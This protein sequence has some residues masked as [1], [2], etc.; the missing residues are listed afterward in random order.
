MLMGCATMLWL[1]GCCHKIFHDVL[2]G[3]GAQ[4]TRARAQR[5]QHESR[6]ELYGTTAVTALSPE[7]RASASLFVYVWHTIEYDSYVGGKNHGKI[8]I[9]KKVSSLISLLYEGH[10]RAFFIHAIALLLHCEM[11]SCR[12]PPSY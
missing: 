12:H 6:A 11:S 7:C 1:A 2:R 8:F 10:Y 3:C 9:A 4:C 5:Y